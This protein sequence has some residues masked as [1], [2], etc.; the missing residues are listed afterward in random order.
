[1]VCPDC[2]SNNIEAHT[3]GIILGEDVNKAWCLDCK[4][5][6][7]AQQAIDAENLEGVK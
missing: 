6:G 3:A 1:M 4:W 7:I 2:K 5:V